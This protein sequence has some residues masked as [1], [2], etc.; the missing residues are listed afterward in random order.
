MVLQVN[1]KKK[2]SG[3]LNLQLHLIKRRFRPNITYHPQH[4]KLI[5]EV[6][7]DL[8]PEDNVC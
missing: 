5:V 4:T 6:G 8:G 2:K 7:R 1:N 3:G